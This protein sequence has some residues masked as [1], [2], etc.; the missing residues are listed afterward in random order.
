MK[1]HLLFPILDTHQLKLQLLHSLSNVLQQ[2]LLQKDV[3]PTDIVNCMSIVND[4]VTECNANA[5]TISQRL[6][7]L[8]IVDDSVNGNQ[9]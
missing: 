6:S 5:E 7:E 8:Y 9:D 2:S 4:L 1:K 3:R